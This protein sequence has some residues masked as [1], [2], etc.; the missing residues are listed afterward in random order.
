MPE[1]PCDACSSTVILM[2][3]D[4]E[5]HCDVLVAVGHHGKPSF[6]VEG[7]AGGNV[8]SLRFQGGGSL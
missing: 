7:T 6:Y 3:G 5:L 2:T 1:R 8:S 4:I